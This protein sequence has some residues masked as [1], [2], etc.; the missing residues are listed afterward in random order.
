MLHQ[1]ALKLRFA[2]HFILQAWWH[3]HAPGICLNQTEYVQ[4]PLGCG[5]KGI[6]GL[7]E[8]DLLK[9]TKEKGMCMQRHLFSAA[10]HLLYC[11]LQHTGQFAGHHI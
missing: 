7:L 10:L 4:D 11:M 2:M 8:D 1:D 3:E 9:L 5:S 6:A